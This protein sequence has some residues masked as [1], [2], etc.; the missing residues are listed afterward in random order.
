MNTAHIY[1]VESWILIHHEDDIVEQSKI[2]HVHASTFSGEERSMQNLRG[3]S[4]SMT[5]DEPLLDQ[6]ASVFE[7]IPSLSE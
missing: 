4:Y 1:C 2:V 6:N 7:V 3:Q 5:S